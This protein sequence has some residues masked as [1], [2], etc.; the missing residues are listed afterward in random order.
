MHNKDEAATRLAS[1]LP[2]ETFDVGDGPGA[3]RGIGKELDLIGRLDKA[4][5]E[6]ERLSLIE[7]VDACHI[8]TVT[9]AT[10]EDGTFAR[11]T[12]DEARLIPYIR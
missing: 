5:V 3:V 6:R 7:T 8:P 2:G 9:K 11:I 12:S 10:G 4:E 1:E